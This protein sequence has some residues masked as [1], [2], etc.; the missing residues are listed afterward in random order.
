MVNWVPDGYVGV[1]CSDI[2]ATSHPRRGRPRS[3]GQRAA[4]GAVRPGGDHLGYQQDLPGALAVAEHRAEYFA[5]FYGPTSRP[6]PP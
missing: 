4:A 2:G 5:T 1:R 6:S 3:V